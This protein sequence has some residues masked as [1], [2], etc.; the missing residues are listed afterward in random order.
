VKELFLGRISEVA[1]KLRKTGAE[2]M[3]PLWDVGLRRTNFCSDIVFASFKGLII[4]QQWRK[5]AHGKVCKTQ[6]KCGII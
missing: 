3:R 2:I 5:M 1:L 6:M 4:L